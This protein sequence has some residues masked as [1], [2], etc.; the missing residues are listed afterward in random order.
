MH[1]DNGFELDLNP[2]RDPLIT[3]GSGEYDGDCKSFEEIKPKK[4]QIKLSPPYG[5]NGIFKYSGSSD[6]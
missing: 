2:E 5:N 1:V 6:L 4:I 3:T